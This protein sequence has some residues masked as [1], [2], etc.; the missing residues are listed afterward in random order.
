MVAFLGQCKRLWCLWFYNSQGGNHSERQLSTCLPL[1]ALSWVPNR[2]FITDQ[3][4]TLVQMACRA[5]AMLM[6]LENNKDKEETY[7]KSLVEYFHFS[8]FN[9]AVTK[10]YRVVILISQMEIRVWEV[11]DEMIYLFLQ[12]WIQSSGK[13]SLKHVSNWYLTVLHPQTSG[14][15]GILQ[16]LLRDSS[17][18]A[19][20]S[21]TCFLST[22]I[23]MNLKQPKGTCYRFWKTQNVVMEAVVVVVVMGFLCPV[24][25]SWVAGCVRVCVFRPLPM[26]THGSAVYTDGTLGKA[27]R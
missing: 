25:L 9:I 23:L 26:C 21:L 16:L 12:M 8:S 24:L 1:T 5:K 13:V 18:L 15:N 10:G 19:K 20:H 7:T 27:F 22:Q 17:G 6:S 2:A 11:K 14:T 4:K 3:A